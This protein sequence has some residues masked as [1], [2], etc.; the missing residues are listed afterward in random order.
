LNQKT[1]NS[2]VDVK[3]PNA[4][5]GVEALNIAL[6]EIIFKNIEWLNGVCR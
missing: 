1:F 6:S 5:G 4:Q 3:T 2:R